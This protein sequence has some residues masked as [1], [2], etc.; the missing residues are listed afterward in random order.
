MKVDDA[1]RCAR[2][3]T[4]DA[5][6]TET[7]EVEHPKTGR[8]ICHASLGNFARKL[9]DFEVRCLS[10]PVAA[11]VYKCFVPAACERDATQLLNVPKKEGDHVIDYTIY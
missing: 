6:S 5:T 10:Q 1:A 3:A 8:C 7:C 4:L 9:V 2:R 11:F